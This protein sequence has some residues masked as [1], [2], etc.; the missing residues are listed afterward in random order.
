MSKTDLPYIFNRFYKA[1]KA[2]IRK[3]A[4]SGLGFAITKKLLNCIMG[5]F[6]L[7]AK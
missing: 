4:S 3:K 1:N 7:K 5:K 6:R 2:R